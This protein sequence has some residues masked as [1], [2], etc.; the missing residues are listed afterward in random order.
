[1]GPKK[2]IAKKVSRGTSSSSEPFN[3]TRYHTVENFKK[4]DTLVKFRSI[5]TERKVYLDELDPFTQQNLD[6]R[7]W[8]PICTSLKSPPAVIIRE[9][10]YIMSI[11]ST[12]SSGHFLTTWIQGD[13][14][15]ITKKVMA[16]AL[17]IPIV[18]NPAYPYT[19]PPSLN[20]VMSLLCD[21]PMTW[22]N[23]PRL[24]TSEQTEVNY[25]LYRI[26]CQSVFPIDL[27]LSMYALVTGASITLHSLF[28]QTIVEVNRNTSKDCFYP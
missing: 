14:Y 21:K 28:I 8:L 9:I 19:N 24:D 1:M 20:D 13:E 23:K 16:D 15:Q 5:W 7:G 26:G 11:H 18:C 10:L 3:S 6:S 2:T 22:A 12:I 27:C 25:L 17:S 4:Y